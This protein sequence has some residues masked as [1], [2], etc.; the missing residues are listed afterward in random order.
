[1]TE[2]EDRKTVSQDLSEPDTIEELE[3]HLK[4]LIEINQNLQQTIKYLGQLNT[5]LCEIVSTINNISYACDLHC[6]K[7][8]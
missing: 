2:E 8:K 3:D 7:T 5:K 1:M 6:K 4:L